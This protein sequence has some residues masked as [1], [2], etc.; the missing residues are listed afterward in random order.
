M[1]IT[2]GVP[3]QVPVSKQQNVRIYFW[4]SPLGG[5]YNEWWPPFFLT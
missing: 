2:V 1:L 5:T 3:K 4:P